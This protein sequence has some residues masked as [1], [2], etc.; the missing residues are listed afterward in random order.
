MTVP[1]K[2]QLDLLFTAKEELPGDM[3]INSSH[4]SDHKTVGPKILT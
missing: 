1:L 4:C 3:T 2:P